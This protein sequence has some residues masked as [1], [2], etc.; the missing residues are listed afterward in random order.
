VTSGTAKSLLVLG[1]ASR[2]DWPR[3]SNDLSYVRAMSLRTSDF[4]NPKSRVS[5]SEALIG[6]M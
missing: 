1:E 6:T 3:G 5:L 2:S 4:S